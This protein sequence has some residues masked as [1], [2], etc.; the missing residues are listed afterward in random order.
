MAK[1]PAET[2][3][4]FVALLD[5]VELH[6]KKCKLCQGSPTV[7]FTEH[8]FLALSKFQETLEGMLNKRLAG[9]VMR[10]S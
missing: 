2:N 6:D 10:F 4:I 9:E 1:K 8:Y 3:A 5:P 7:R